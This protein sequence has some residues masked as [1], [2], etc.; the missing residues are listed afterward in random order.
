MKSQV[1]WLIE[2]GV[3]G[4]AA[5]GS[6]GEGHVLVRDEYRQLIRTTVEAIDGRIPLV[7]GIIANSTA[8]VI[9][10]GQVVK[11]LGVAALQITR[12]TIYSDLTMQ[13]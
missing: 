3:H 9:A 11:D 10:R 5:G 1:D 4:L 12:L 7:A 13:P 2:N 8:E 6:T